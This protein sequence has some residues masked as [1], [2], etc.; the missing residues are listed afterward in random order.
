MKVSIN[1][2]SWSNNNVEVVNNHKMVMDHFHIPVNYTEENINHG[3]WIDRTLNTVDADIFVFMDSDCVPLSRVALDESIDYCKRGYLIGNAQVTN[4][5]SAKH[6]LFCAPSFF[7]ISKEMYFALGKPSAVNNNDRRTDIAQEFTRKAVEQE[8][9][10][11]MHYPTSFQGVPQGGIW[12]LS[13]YGYYGIGTVYDNKFYHLYQTRFAKN[14]G[15]FVDTCNH[16]V[17]GNIDGIN[18]QYD[19]K[20]EWAGVLPI[21][22]DYGY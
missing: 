19:C 20:S 13:G 1:T 15:L 3:M 6:D 14:V 5:I 16:I 7:V 12:R 2:L 8:R 22:D 21:E 18:R 11:K 9:R 10:I 17:S 4:C